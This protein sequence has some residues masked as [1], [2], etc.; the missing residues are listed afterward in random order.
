MP[1][2][3]TLAQRAPAPEDNVQ[4]DTDRGSL[5]GDG[6]LGGGDAMVLLGHDTP[7]A[8]AWEAAATEREVE[9]CAAPCGCDLCERADEAEEF[10][11]F[12]GVLS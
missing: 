8:L 5:P 1:L 7:A 9:A 12:D 6:V 10:G 2:R 3:V 4:T 11:L